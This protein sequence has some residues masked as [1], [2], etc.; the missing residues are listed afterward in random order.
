MTVAGQQ[1]PS[2]M[3]FGG[4][5]SQKVSAGG[6]IVTG[7]KGW[8]LR[9][10]TIA[11]MAAILAMTINTGISTGDPLLIFSNIMPL[12]SILALYVGWFHYRNPARG[13]LGNDLVSVIIPVYNQ[14]EMIETVVAAIFRS[15]YRNIEVIAIN[16]G[17]SDGSKEILDALAKK[18][19]GL[20][21]IHK[22][23]A[24][25]R[26]A[27]AAGI[28]AARGK[29]L[30]LLDSDSVVDPDAIA[31]MIKAFKA[32]PMIGGAVGH[33]KVWNADKNFLT[34]FQDSWYDFSFNIGKACESTFGSVTCCS[35]CLAAYRRDVVLHFIRHW[36][37]SKVHSSDDRELTSYVATSKWG[38]E[39]MREMMASTPVSE[40]LFQAAASYD[41]AEDRVMTASTLEKWKTVYVSTAIVYT[42]VPEKFRGFLRQQERWKKGYVRTN[43]FVSSFFWHRRNPLMTFVFYTEFMATFSAPLIVLAVF[44]YAPLLQH[45]YYYSLSFIAALLMK[46]VAIGLDYRYRDPAAKNWKYY[47]L[48]VAVTNFVLSWVL[49]PALY[50]FRENRWLT[51]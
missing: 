1:Q 6:R 27:V 20:K 45:Q 25:K 5:C 8:A 46:G 19:P 4:T 32:D 31:E 51:R 15:T 50:R 29:Y 26:K 35:G 24:G 44:L 48:T 34:R 3:R 7:K 30:L 10:A 16:D 2:D 47:P 36:A 28:Y 39:K 23:N 40:K 12:H 49:F 14:K 18:E 43:F 9:V 21:V 33:V 42:D 17:S 41:D 22:K 13:K 38:K 37:D 11:G